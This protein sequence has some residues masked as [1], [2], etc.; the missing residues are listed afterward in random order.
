MKLLIRSQSKLSLVESK[1]LNIIEREG[2]WHIVKLNALFNLECR[3][4]L[5]VYKTKERALEV[6]D[7]IQRILMPSIRAYRSLTENK[8]DYKNHCFKTKLVG[9]ETEYDIVDIPTYVYEMPEE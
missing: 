6:L 2:K 3:I 9:Y 1:N 7:E 5:G 8:E 4:E